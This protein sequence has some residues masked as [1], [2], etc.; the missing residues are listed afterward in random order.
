[1]LRG[2][3]RGGVTRAEDGSWAGLEQGWGV[4]VDRGWWL[5]VGETVCCF[6]LLKIKNKPICAQRND[7]KDLEISE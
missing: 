4:A 6:S 1:M 5:L 2:P 3:Q 7:V